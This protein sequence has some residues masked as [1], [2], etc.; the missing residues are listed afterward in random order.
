[1]PTPEQRARLKSLIKGLDRVLVAY[2]GGIDSTLVLKLAHDY[3]G[4][5]AAAAIAVSPSLAGH[6]LAD[7]RRVAQEIGCQLIELSSTETEDPRYQVNNPDRCYFCKTNVYDTLID[8]AGEEGYRWILDGTNCDDLGDH[9]PGLRAAREHGVRS[10]LQECGLGKE[11]IRTYARE[12]GLSNWDKPANACL[13]SRIPYGSTV[14][15]EKLSQ[16]EKAELIL[17]TLGFVGHRVRHHDTIARLELS[18]DQFNKAIA[19][20]AE[21]VEALKP[22]GFLYITLDLGGYV[23]GSLNQSLPSPS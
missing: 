16:V 11:A 5:N 13:S 23:S 20:H 18:A 12:L 6:D 17:K 1:M 15:P 21:L 22:L 19:Q 3:L 14:T 7:A 10:P 8:H 2:S 4:E 9:R